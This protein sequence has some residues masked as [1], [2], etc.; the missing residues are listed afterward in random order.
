MKIQYPLSKRN[1]DMGQPT[2]ARL[3]VEVASHSQAPYRG[4]AT[5]HGHN[6]LQC[7][8]CKGGRLQ[9]ACKER[10]L[11]ARVVANNDSGADHKSDDDG[12][13]GARG[14]RAILL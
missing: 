14:V 13:K 10:P 4:W 1:E 8:T 7:D 12:A 9:G 11:A 6:H 3:S 5:A 2:M